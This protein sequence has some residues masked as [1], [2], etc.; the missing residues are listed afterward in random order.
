MLSVTSLTHPT[1]IA[2]IRAGLHYALMGHGHKMNGH[3][4]RV[5]IQN[6]QGRNIMRLDWIGNGN[7]I[8][9]GEESRN[10]TTIVKQALKLASMAE[11]K[12]IPA[13]PSDEAKAFI[14]GNPDLQA[15][16]VKLATL[17]GMGAMLTACSNHGAVTSVLTVVGSLFT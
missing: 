14:A 7:Y 13:T 15:R 16:L 6:A 3:R 10:I 2:K 4:N 12:A 1:M 9:Y 8:V 11:A 5:Y 17:A